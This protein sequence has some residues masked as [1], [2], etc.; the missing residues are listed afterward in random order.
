MKAFWN[1]VKDPLQK[2]L[3]EALRIAVAA[4]LPLIIYQLELGQI[5]WKSIALVVAVALL[6]GADKAVHK[7]GEAEGNKTLEGGLV[8]F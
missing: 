1:K 4:A 3:T 2:G 8:R 5:E 7:F 6:K